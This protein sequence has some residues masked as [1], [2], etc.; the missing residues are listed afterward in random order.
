MEDLEDM[1]D[2][3]NDRRPH[4]ITKDEWNTKIVNERIEAIRDTSDISDGSHTFGELYHHRA[5]LF[6]VI[7]NMFPDSAW[8]SM[9]HCNGGYIKGFFIVGIETPEG[10]FAYH[11]PVEDWDLFKVEKLQVA[12]VWD[13]HTSKDVTRLFSL[14]N[15]ED[16]FFG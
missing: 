11:Y 6:A 8:K 7:C 16:N 9:K 5:V 10:Q 12:P 2:S 3:L 15:D 1:L 13:G 4:S 14:I